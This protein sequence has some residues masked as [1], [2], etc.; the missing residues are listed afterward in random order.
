M[1]VGY[2]IKS[3][4]KGLPFGQ[5]GQVA[6]SRAF[7]IEGDIQ[8]DAHNWSA[9]AQAYRNGLSIR[10]DNFPIWVQ[11]GNVLK[12]GGKLDDAE[13]AYRQGL[14]INPR[15]PDL[16]VQLG[17]L[18]NRRGDTAKTQEYYSAAIELGSMDEH[19]RYQEPQPDACMEQD[20]AGRAA[21][22]LFM[23][24]DALRNEHSWANAAAA[25]AEGL[26]LDPSAFGI[27]VQLGNMLKEAKR[28]LEAEA[29][30]NEAFRLSPFDPDLMLQMGHLFNV[31]GDPA[32]A[33]R[34]YG[35]SVSLG[36]RDKNAVQFLISHP[37]NDALIGE[38]AARLL[39]GNKRWRAFSRQPA[40]ISF[41][42]FILGITGA[43]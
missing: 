33:C 1:A 16:N 26:E 19:A 10:P 38:M 9:A 29:A 17:H 43:Q 25:Y 27:W 30:Y 20:A 31:I 24:A 18:Y 22:E 14:E 12:E 42:S 36:L 41:T 34:A 35:Q 7:F 40:P 15:D 11:L 13:Q 5:R 8:R 39:P 6:Q 23:A 37:G 3:K 2:S 4:I 28:P 21:A 32:R